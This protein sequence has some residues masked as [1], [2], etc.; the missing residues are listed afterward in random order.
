V[1][2]GLDEL[3]SETH[4]IIVVEGLF[5][6]VSVDFALNL[7]SSDEVK[8]VAVNTKSIS[9]DQQW[10]IKK[11]APNIDQLIIWF[12]PDAHKDSLAHANKF[13][14]DFN[15]VGILYD[16]ENDPGSLSIQDIQSIFMSRLKTSVSFR[17][18]VLNRRK[19]K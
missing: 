11:Y 16:S 19:L 7:Q 15:K 10:L 12:D 9:I 6:K 13:Y 3:N 18:D 8:C 14:F 5:D 1:V 2:V 17:T 4:T